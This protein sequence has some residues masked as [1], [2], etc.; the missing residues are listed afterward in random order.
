MANAIPIPT[1]TK[2]PNDVLDYSWD[3][4]EWLSGGDA[5]SAATVYTP[6]GLT[7]NSS[8]FTTSTVT[9]WLSGGQVGQP[10]RVTARITTSEG[11]T[12]DRSIVVAIANQ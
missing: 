3:F 12:V 10:Y 8:S 2:D 6:A 7:L 5:I 4:T 9:A 1:W 11:R